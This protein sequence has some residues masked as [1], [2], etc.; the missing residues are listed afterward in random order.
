MWCGDFVYRVLG[1][2]LTQNDKQTIEVI[3][4]AQNNYSRGLITVGE[5]IDKL[6]NRSK[7][8]E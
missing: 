3:S 2:K 4:E 8:L 7:I 6:V 1:Y 5:N